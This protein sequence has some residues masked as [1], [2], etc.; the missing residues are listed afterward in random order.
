M[1]TVDF[2]SAQKAQ[3]LW[4]TD[5]AYDHHWICHRG[6]TTNINTHVNAD[7]EVT[8][9]AGAASPAQSSQAW[10]SEDAEASRNVSLK[11][12]RVFEELQAGR[13]CARS[14][15]PALSAEE[16]KAD[17]S[18]KKSP[19]SLSTLLQEVHNGPHRC[20]EDRGD[21]RRRRRKEVNLGLKTPALCRTVSL[22]VRKLLQLASS[23]FSYLI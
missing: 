18:G 14:R 6:Y 9:A 22:A 11:I 17:K 15:M 20:E 19:P 12:A 21:Q 5:A 3:H 7:F 8:A 23:F 13:A 10:C 4:P 2:D 16:E 1:R